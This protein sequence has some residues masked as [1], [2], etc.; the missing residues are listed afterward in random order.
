MLSQQEYEKIHWQMEHLPISFTDQQKR[1][2][3]R[4]MQKKLKEHRY[5]ST[6]PPFQPLPYQLYYVNR[7][8]TEHTLM[9]LNDHINNSN[10]FTLDTEAVNILHQPNKPALIQLQIILSQ[11]SSIMVFVETCHLPRLDQP[12]FTLIKNLFKSLFQQIKTIFIWGDIDELIPFTRYELFTTN[13]IYLSYNVNV[14]KKFKKYWLDNYPHQSASSS[15]GTSTCRC[16]TCF[17]IEHDNL[18]S[19][20]DAVAFELNRWIDKRLTRQP[21][22]IGLDPSLQYLNSGQTNYRQSLCVYAA[23]DCDAIYQLIVSTDIISEQ[24][25]S[26][27]YP[28]TTDVMIPVDALSPLD[29][30]TNESPSILFN[31]PTTTTNSSA[32]NVV[33]SPAEPL[34]YEPIS[35]EDETPPEIEKQNQQEE[36]LSAE[37]RKKIHNR[38]CTLRQ[39]RRL[40]QNEIILRNIDRRFTIT[41]IKQILQENHVVYCA[42]NNPTSKLTNKTSLFIGVEDKKLIPEYRN[43]IKH[44]FDSEHY[45]Q[46]R[47]NRYRRTSITRRDRHH[48]K[49][50]KR[51]YR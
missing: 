39:R 43:K 11:S 26:I 31:H 29:D 14:Q 6:Y 46:I 12:Q 9:K 38:S 27:E 2:F 17:G 34:G 40:Y 20:Q 23:N 21:F 32:N 7:T 28:L 45:E 24:H 33:Q 36:K 41:T 48:H 25:Q 19:I 49:E 10:L 44:L 15:N 5:A 51:T 1:S 35:S 47:M 42:V 4:T 18:I 16:R 30:P 22:D 3:C 50:H 37:Q 8:T 13:Q